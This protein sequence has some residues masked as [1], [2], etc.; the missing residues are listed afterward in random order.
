MVGAL[1]LGLAPQL[2][3]AEMVPDRFYEVVVP[4]M[5]TGRVAFLQDGRVIGQ[6]SREPELEEKGRWWREGGLLCLEDEPGDDP[7]CLEELP[8]E[9]AEGFRLRYRIWRAELTPED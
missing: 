6:R 9:E 8:H 5:L 7:I 4:G 1:A 3:A 2:S